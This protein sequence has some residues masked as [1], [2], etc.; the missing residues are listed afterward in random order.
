MPTYIYVSQVG[1]GLNE[2]VNAPH[3][4]SPLVPRCDLELYHGKQH[5][6]QLQQSP[7]ASPIQ[8]PKP[9]LRHTTRLITAHDNTTTSSH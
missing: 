4:A 3:L 1:L 2:L 5:L 7:F 6:D 9:T 8:Q